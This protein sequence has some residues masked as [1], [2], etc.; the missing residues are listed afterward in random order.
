MITAA[1]LLEVYPDANEPNFNSIITNKREFSELILKKPSKFGD[2]F[3][4]QEILLR[5]MSTKTNITEMFILWPTGR[6]KTRAALELAKTV[7]H[8]TEQYGT[9]EN[10]LRTIVIA[11]KSVLPAW[12][13]E[14]AKMPE[15]IE[16]VKKDEMYTA[17]GLKRALSS[18]MNKYFDL[19]KADT[20]SNELSQLTNDQ[21]I[22][23]YSGRHIYIDEAHSLR[24]TNGIGELFRDKD[25]IVTDHL[26]D[27]NGEIIARDTVSKHSYIQIRRLMMLVK[28]CVKI[29][30]TATPIPDKIKDFPSVVSFILPEDRQL[31]VADLQNAFDEAV[32][33]D[34]DEPLFNYLEPK[35]R[36]RISYVPSA[37][38]I[39]KTIKE[40]ANNPNAGTFVRIVNDIEIKTKLKVWNCQM[41]QEQYD[42]YSRYKNEDDREDDG[43]IVA[44]EID[45]LN[46]T[47]TVRTRQ[48]LNFVFLK[49]NSIASV[50]GFEYFEDNS[51]KQ[52]EREKYLNGNVIVT[53]PTIMTQDQREEANQK[54]L[55]RKQT[56]L[57]KNKAP[58]PLKK[59][60]EGEHKFQF[61]FEKELFKNAE[62]RPKNL[63]FTD[64]LLTLIPKR[65]NIIRRM[66]AKAYEVILLVHHN[67]KFPGE[68]EFTYYYHKWIREGG[69]ILLGMC[70]DLIGYDRFNGKTNRADQLDD[71]PRYA[72]MMGKPGSTEAR[73]SN[74]Q[75]VVNNPL[76]RFGQKV[77]IIIASAVTA[78]GWSFLNARKFI[79]GGPD[80]TL[81][82][83]PMGRAKRSDSH[84]AFDR[85]NQK[86]VRVFL[87]AATTPSGEQT[88]DHKIWFMTEQKKNII[89]RPMR[90]LKRIAVDCS[91]NVRAGEQGK[92]YGIN[93]NPNGSPIVNPRIRSIDMT[94]YHLHW[95][96]DEFQTIENKLRKM[97]KIVS[98]LNFSQIVELLEK[99]HHQTTIIWTLT[100]LLSRDELI[101]DRFGSIKVLKESK[102]VY[103]LS[104]LNQLT[105]DANIAKS[106]SEFNINMEPN[107]QKIIQSYNKLQSVSEL[108]KTLSQFTKYWTSDKSTISPKLK[109]II[110]EK[111]LL[112]QIEQKDIQNY[113]LKDYGQL[114]FTFTKE[115][116]DGNDVTVVFHYLKEMIELSATKYNM[117]MMNDNAKIRIKYSNIPGEFRDA[118]DN[119]SKN[120]VKLVNKRWEDEEKRIL[121]ESNLN[122]IVIYNISSDRNY[123]L[124]IY[125]ADNSK[126]KNKKADDRRCSIA[127]KRVDYFTFDVL[128]SYIWEA[129]VEPD[130]P[131][132]TLVNPP[133]PPRSHDL[134]VKQIAKSLIP[135]DKEGLKTNALERDIQTW[136]QE[137]LIFYFNWLIRKKHNKP[138]IIPYLVNFMIERNWLF[139]K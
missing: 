92:C 129:G 54:K 93:I 53:P 2:K 49:P 26:V 17:K 89:K 47:F 56:K 97:F 24:N 45:T 90:V 31:N 112:N 13:R 127:G 116:K 25:G 115:S 86:Y 104:D 122:F 66:S 69:G 134:F 46:D 126:N 48:A 123:R 79:H 95:A 58:E 51:L 120:L 88:T 36:G 10:D 130:E 27:D 41:L 138:M 110:F 111:A 98:Y 119:E 137:R 15:F 77:A 71:R 80:Y 8:Y 59:R 81:F 12:H 78:T 37:V 21:I 106:I 63:K 22:K 73:N 30:M 39:V 105:N 108:P 124:K 94:T 87:L 109:L 135:S 74:I 131:D 57:E 35:L 65:M 64:D 20:F 23:R 50:E 6:G 44:E 114:W 103:Y 83:Q 5:I 67:L 84:R 9:A 85:D 32:K 75:E 18:S 118:K 72:Y 52:K 3:T 16:N 117:D 107:F 125:N 7:M 133:E 136:P 43:E 113:I 139:I 128:M 68:G 96:E 132:K 29:V 28:N 19:K 76:N 55:E 34:N 33:L 101:E 82:D 121:A 62:P 14:I 38:D 60:S 102:G 91:L 42:V 70:F 61:R 100:R 99:E 1:D 11:P 4:Y 40:P